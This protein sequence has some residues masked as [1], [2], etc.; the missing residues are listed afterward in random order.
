M[1]QSYVRAILYLILFFG[2]VSMPGS[3]LS[4]RSGANRGDVD[5]SPDGKYEKAIFAGG[6]FWC[7]ESAFE[8]VPGVVAAVSGYTGGDKV[9]PSYQDVSSGV[10]GHKEVVEVTFDPA[11]VSYQE[12]LNIFWR[13]IDPTDPGGQFADRGSQYS[14]AIF[15]L[16]ERQRVLAQHSKEALAKSGRFKRPIVTEIIKVAEFYPAENYHQ[17]YAQEHPLQY[18]FYRFGSGRD[19]FLKKAWGSEAHPAPKRKA[20]AA[21]KNKEALK[22]RLTPLQYKVTQQDGTEPPFKNAYWDN[23]QDGIYVDIVSGEPLFSSV[24]KYDSGTGWPSFV[25]PLVPENIVEKEDRKLFMARTEVRSKQA[26]SH[27][28]HVFPDGPD[29]TGLRYCINS[30][31]LRFILKEDLEKEGLSAYR[32]LFE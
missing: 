13:N 25:R 18:K 20:A 32:D 15:Y 30:A 8:A 16:D 31:A 4:G 28:G 2:V 5:M 11:R 29:P 1:K 27:L 21:A 14:S 12:L 17:D 10:T 9:E 6:C 22:S 19:Q 24:D 7:V 26:D 3:A 23:K